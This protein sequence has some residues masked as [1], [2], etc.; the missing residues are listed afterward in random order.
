MGSGAFILVLLLVVALVAV[1]AA[2]RWRANQER[3]QKL[4]RFCL[5]KGWGFI[6]RDDELTTR[7]RCPPFLE[8]RDRQ[9]RDVVTGTVGHPARRF[10]AFDYSY[11]TDNSDG[12][13]HRS[14]TK[15][16]YAICAL[17][18]SAYF[19]RLEVTPAT[20]LTRI[21][22]ALTGDDIELESEAFNRRFRVRCP[23]PRFAS[24]VLTPRTM[25][26]LLSRTPL[27]LRFEGTELLC[28]EAGVSTPVALLERLSTLERFVVGIPEFVWHDYG[29]TNSGT[30]PSAGGAAQ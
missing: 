8:G 11:V 24:D 27:H 19:P 30:E 6:A 16:R 15:H 29:V 23:D 4:A 12:R 7:W 26:A 1:V 10:V 13:G 25:Q 20:V 28:W 2:L 5:A 9:A 14:S 21:G 18:A 3:V 22:N 17:T